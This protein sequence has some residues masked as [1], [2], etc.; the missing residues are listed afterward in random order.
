MQRCDFAYDVHWVCYYIHPPI[1]NQKYFTKHKTFFVLSRIYF[2]LA[3]KRR[4]FWVNF[5]S[6]IGGRVQFG[7]FSSTRCVL[8]PQKPEN[9]LVCS[10]SGLRPPHGASL[11]IPHPSTL[12]VQNAR[13]KSSDF[14]LPEAVVGLCPQ[15][16]YTP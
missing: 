11:D 9:F 7:A 16:A 14:G 8:L 12:S 1:A 3:P 10:C 13:L 4:V 6:G 2:V 15:S 5:F